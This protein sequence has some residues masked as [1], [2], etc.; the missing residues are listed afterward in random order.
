MNKQRTRDTVVRLQDTERQR[1][2]DTQRKEGEK[3]QNNEMCICVAVEREIVWKGET[4]RNR[5]K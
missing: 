4:E 1:Q 5:E 3:T 2:T